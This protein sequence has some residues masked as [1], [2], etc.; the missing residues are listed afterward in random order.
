MTTAIQEVVAE[1]Q[2]LQVWLPIRTRAGRATVR[3]VDGVS[4][5]IRRGQ[6][7]GLVGESG[8]GKSTTA[9]ALVGLV[10]PTAGR[11]RILGQDVT[12]ASRRQLRSL[13]RRVAIAF[14]DPQ[15]SLDPRCAIGTSIAEPIRVHRLRQPST[16]SHAR[17]RELLDLV[18]LPA[19]TVSRHPHE[20]SGGQRQRV[21]IARALAGEPDLIV[22]DEPLGSL[23]V[24]VQAQIMNLL[25]SLQA[26]LRLT[27]LF[28]A[29]DLGAVE[30]MSDS[31]AVMHLGRIVET[32]PAA[33]LYQSPAHPYTRALLAAIP[34]QTPREERMREKII[35][36]GDIPSPINPPSGCRFHTR[37]PLA[38][39]IC[40]TVDPPSIGVGQDHTA[41]CHLAQMPT[42]Q[43][44][45]PIIRPVNAGRGVHDE[46]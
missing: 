36:R 9:L 33:E 32:A 8:S 29:H 23:D 46:R 12:K 41:A 37:C 1:V 13:R 43:S 40:L 24:S 42:T 30:Y 44:G 45:E 20:L 38:M 22:L 17:V 11:V 14:Q 19:D 27:Y 6:T 25:R 2:D 26:E 16:A 39:Q 35:L 15:T 28:I 4:F 10:R 21:G 5:V 18:G 31:V 7:L 34:A 3:A